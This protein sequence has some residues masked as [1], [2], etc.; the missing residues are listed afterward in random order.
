MMF[1]QAT[2]SSLIFAFFFHNSLSQEKEHNNIT[3]NK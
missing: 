2:S 3:D 1:E